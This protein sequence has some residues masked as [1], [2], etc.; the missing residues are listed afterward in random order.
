MRNQGDDGK[1]GANEIGIIRKQ[2]QDR[3]A[4]MEQ[5]QQRVDSAE[6]RIKALSSKDAAHRASIAAITSLVS[7]SQPRLSAHSDLHTTEKQQHYLC[8]ICFIVG[9]CEVMLHV[10]TVL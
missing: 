10:C 2:L 4:E 5:A 3:K 8:C 1:G 6:L 7:A 9:S